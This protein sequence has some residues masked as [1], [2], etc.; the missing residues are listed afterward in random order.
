MNPRVLWARF[1]QRY[2]GVAKRLAPFATIG[3]ICTTVQYLLAL[4]LGAMTTVFVSGAIAWFVAGQFSYQLHRRITWGDRSHL[5][6]NLD[7]AWLWHHLKRW[8]VFLACNSFAGFLNVSVQSTL[9]TFEPLDWRPLVLLIATAF[10]FPIN[11][12]LQN[13]YVFKKQKEGGA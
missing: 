9:S 8:A 10:T 4:L 1:A 2:P 11:M 6:T 3:V 5:F 7:I 13:K 12:G